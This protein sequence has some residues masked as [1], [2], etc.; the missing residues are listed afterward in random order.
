MPDELEFLLSSGPL[1]QT[2]PLVAPPILLS[3]P[4]SDAGRLVEGPFAH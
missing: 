3:E 2:A 4:L 1:T